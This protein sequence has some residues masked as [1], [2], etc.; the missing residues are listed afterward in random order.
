TAQQGADGGAG[1]QGEERLGAQSVHSAG[2]TG[3]LKLPGQGGE[4]LIGGQDRRGGKV[5]SRQGGGP[6]MLVPALDPGSLLGALLAPPGSAGSGGQHRAAGG[7]TQLPGGL[8][9]R[10]TGD[11]M[12]N[13][14]RV[15]VIEPR[16]LVGDHHGPGQVDVPGGERLAGQRQ[17]AQGNGK[18]KHSVRGA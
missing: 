15:L 8:A 17:T 6:G 11:V 12:L 14:S 3:G 2:D 13:G 5:A 9:W 7:G 10:R 18:I 4:V 16:D 1:E